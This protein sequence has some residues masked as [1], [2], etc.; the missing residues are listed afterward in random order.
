MSTLSA[1]QQ[2]D[3]LKREGTLLLRDVRRKQDERTETAGLSASQ[4]TETAGTNANMLQSESEG[5]ATLRQLEAE[6][7]WF[8]KK[9]HQRE[10]ELL[11]EENVQRRS[12]MLK[13]IKDKEEENLHDEVGS[14]T[15]S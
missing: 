7:A 9:E 8:D 4:H 3:P 12:E 10:K 2:V 6:H 14:Y 11:R 1:T 13:R 15:S 5:Q